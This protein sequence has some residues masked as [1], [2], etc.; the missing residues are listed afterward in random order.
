MGPKRP[1]NKKW[2]ASLNVSL[3]T[4]PGRA[5]WAAC[6][7]W[8]RPRPSPSASSSSPPGWRGGRWP[9]AGC[10]FSLW[11]EQSLSAPAKKMFY[12]QMVEEGHFLSSS[13][14]AQSGLELHRELVVTRTRPQTLTVAGDECGDGAGSSFKHTGGV[15]VNQHCRHQLAVDGGPAQTEHTLF[16]YSFILHQVHYWSPPITRGKLKNIFCVLRL[17]P[18]ARAL[19]SD[20]C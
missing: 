4:V 14:K 7:R 3:L 18:A 9:A 13:S 20:S 6:R 17:R 11:A 19:T 5:G 16:I 1:K 10:T 15:G 2:I 12:L 8:W